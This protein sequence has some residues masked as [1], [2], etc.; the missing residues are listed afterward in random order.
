MAISKAKVKRRVKRETRRAMTPLEA[1][2]AVAEVA[3]EMDDG[4]KP[5]ITSLESG[6]QPGSII[7]DTKVIYTYNDLVRMF[8]IVDFVPEANVPL[9]FQG[10]K[11]QAYAGVEMHVPKCFKDIY[12]KSR[13]RNPEMRRELRDM[14]IHIEE[15][16]GTTI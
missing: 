1:K 5:A 10:V 9:T 12:D 7:G 15:G 4:I 3:Q 2:E 13:R 6:R 14:G 11:V 16:A 8:P